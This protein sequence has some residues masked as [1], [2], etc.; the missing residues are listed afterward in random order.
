M[1]RLLV[2]AL[3]VVVTGCG[4]DAYRSTRAVPTSAE[5]A[6]R[7]PAALM[8][9][10]DR[11]VY[12]LPAAP[13][14][15]DGVGAPRRGCRTGPQFPPELLVG[16][17]NAPRRA[18]TS[19]PGRPLASV[20]KTDHIRSDMK[21][22]PLQLVAMAPDEGER[23]RQTRL[24]EPLVMSETA[25]QSTPGPGVKTIESRDLATIEQHGR[26]CP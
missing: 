10:G 17:Q 16:Q 24:A 11:T 5:P 19:V 9:S 7:G 4:D 15:L 2:C 23:P 22:T 8:R 13:P 3:A 26:L 21:P 1:R 18:Q 20:D 6:L 25:P 12:E 14:D